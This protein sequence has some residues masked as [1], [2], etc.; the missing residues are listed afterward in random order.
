MQHLKE[1]MKNGFSR[2]FRYNLITCNGEYKNCSFKLRWPLASSMY[3]TAQL[4]MFLCNK[5]CP[6]SDEEFVFCFTQFARNAKGLCS[7]WTLKFL[8]REFFCMH[9]SLHWPTNSIRNTFVSPD[10]TKLHV[11]QKTGCL[12]NTGTTIYI[13]SYTS[14]YH[15]Y[16]FR[17]SGKRRCVSG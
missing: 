3:N 15:N 11:K 1:M 6:F 8:T 10:S 9:V 17:S 2:T 12:Q 13:Y 5:T 16:E 14:N 7:I 4:D